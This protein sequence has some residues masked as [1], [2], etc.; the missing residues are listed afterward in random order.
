MLK[1]RLPSLFSKDMADAER[2]RSD[3]NADSASANAD[4]GVD[5]VKQESSAKVPTILESPAVG[6]STD[7]ASA[8]APA[9][10]SVTP[11]DPTPSDESVNA[12][13]N[14][15]GSIRG[16]KRG[17][18]RGSGRGGGFARNSRPKPAESAASI[19]TRNH[20]ARGSR[21]NGTRGATRGR[22]AR[23]GRSG[24]IPSTQ[25]SFLDVANA[26]SHA[27]GAAQ[28]LDNDRPNSPS[29]IIRNLRDRQRELDRTFRKVATAQRAALSDLAERSEEKL[30]RDQKAHMRA[31]EFQEVLGAIDKA[32]KKRTELLDEQLRIRQLHAE[33]KME[34]EKARIRDKFEV[35]P[36]PPLFFTPWSKLYFS[37]LNMQCSIRLK[38][39]EKNIF[40]LPKAISLRFLK[41]VVFPLNAIW[42]RHVSP[43]LRYLD[44][45]G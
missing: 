1:I 20:V 22:P 33:R 44:S 37:N 11:V 32:L 41:I 36:C 9:L 17:R 43:P 16:R 8:T 29:P 42:P 12:Q 38:T 18:P 21:G 5:V 35:R 25:E 19:G 34:C 45:F 2:R 7:I 30:I 15:A 40:L 39:L 23:R 24:G 26:A 31:P 27:N 14:P 28:Q 4:V 10:L 6:I 3:S 13:A